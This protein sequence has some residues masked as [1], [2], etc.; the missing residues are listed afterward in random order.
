MSAQISCN[1]NPME[2]LKLATQVCNDYGMKHCTIQ[3]MDISDD[4]SKDL[5]KP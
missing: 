3:V 5:P 1:G 2:V 4:N